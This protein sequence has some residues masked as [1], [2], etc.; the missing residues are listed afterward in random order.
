MGCTLQKARTVEK[1]R[2]M[3]IGKRYYY[4]T[5]TRADGRFRTHSGSS[6]RG[7]CGCEVSHKCTW[8]DPYQLT[9]E[10]H[11]AI[12]KELQQVRESA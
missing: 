2:F 4:G 11:E 10:R 6:C 1:P 7:R 9:R 5:H 12:I 8:Y 3:S